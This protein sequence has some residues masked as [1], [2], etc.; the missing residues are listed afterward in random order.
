MSR[1]HVL[2]HSR[3]YPVDVEQAFDRLLPHDLA[4]VFSRRYAA[5]PPIR[6][7]RDQSGTWSTPGQTRTIVLSDGGTMQEELIAVERPTR[8]GYRISRVTGPLKPLVTTIDGEWRFEPAGT[9]VRITW[10]WVVH[11]SGI[12]AVAMPVFGRMWQGYARRA[13]DNLEGLLLG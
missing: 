4:L 1:D 6:S 5:I 9:G 12:G 13:F 10:S 3:S 8:F 11:P 7:T 2:S